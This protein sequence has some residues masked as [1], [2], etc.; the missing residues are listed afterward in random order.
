[1]RQGLRH[2]KRALA[3]AQRCL[4]ATRRTP[5]LV[6]VALIG[7]LAFASLRSRS[8]LVGWCAH[9]LTGA[10]GDVQCFQLGHTTHTRPRQLPRNFTVQLD[11]QWRES[12]KG[13]MVDVIA[14][15]RD[16]RLLCTIPKAGSTLLRSLSLA[17]AVGLHLEP[18]N[19][20]DLTLIHPFAAKRLVQLSDFPDAYI[21]QLLQRPTW[22]YSAVVRH[23]LTR[24]LS[25][26]LDKLQRERDFARDPFNDRPVGSFASFVRVL[27]SVAHARPEGLNSTDEHWR[28]Q[29]A[30]CL[31]RSLPRE[32]LSEVV[33]LEDL[34]AIR[35]VYAE[36]FGVYGAR[37][38]TE[39]RRRREHGQATSLHARSAATWLKAYVNEDLARRVR[40]LY[41]EDYE[42]FGYGLWPP[43]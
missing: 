42:R 31:F 40:Q 27:E 5:V 32:A 30:F 39:H 1:M 16:Q 34:A 6:L 11:P 12:L 2:L 3:Y 23:P 33:Q 28:P 36:W 25:A 17:H 19:P 14:F 38:A 21:A 41:R 26:Y 10:D 15:P 9:H 7:L 24:V 8:I 35:R 37:W 43:S 18:T 22:Q 29:S 20:A 4:S 13:V